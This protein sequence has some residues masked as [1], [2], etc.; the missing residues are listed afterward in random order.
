MSVELQ[1]RRLKWA[2]AWALHPQCHV[3]ALAAMFGQM[4]IE[5]EREVE[6]C[7]VKGGGVGAGAHPWLLRLR[8]DLQVLRLSEDAGWMVEEVGED[9]IR[10]FTEPELAEQFGRADLQVLRTRLWCA[11]VPPPGFAA[12]LPEGTCVEVDADG[13]PCLFRCCFRDGAVECGREADS[14]GAL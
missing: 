7:Y 6:P 14:K 12:Q 8:E 3:Q 13:M 11:Q 10:L 5:K 4:R 2:Q 1:V 9:F